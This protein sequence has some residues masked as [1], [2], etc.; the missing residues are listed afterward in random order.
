MDIARVLESFLYSGDA[1][2]I[3]N[4][5]EVKMWKELVAWACHKL[6][7]KEEGAHIGRCLDEEV[8]DNEDQGEEASKWYQLHSVPLRGTKATNRLLC[9]LTKC[10]D[11]NELQ[12]STAL[13]L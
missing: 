10:P 2:K 1:D 8:E 11:W 6:E 13:V 3:F 5:K 4:K 7:D 12:S 9:Y